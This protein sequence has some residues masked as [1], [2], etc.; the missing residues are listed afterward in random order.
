MS[1]ISLLIEKHQLAPA[2]TVVE[3]EGAMDTVRVFT[4]SFAYNF[5]RK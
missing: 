2:V 1:L 3:T 4:C 5:V